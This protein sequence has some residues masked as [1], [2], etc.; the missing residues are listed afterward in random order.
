M[1]QKNVS[2]KFNFIMNALLT[3]SSFVFPLITFPYVS[4]IL[5]PTGLGRVSFAQSLV[6]YFLIFSEL[7]ISSYGIRITAQLR[8]DKL[9]LS[10]NTQELFAINLFMSLVAYASLVLAICMLPKL[11]DNAE[12]ILICSISILF[13]ALGMEWLYKG[14]EQY[15]YITCRSLLFKTISLVLIFVFIHTSAD[16]KAYAL[17]TVF[18]TSASGILNFI[19]VRRYI[20][21]KPCFGYEFRHHFKAILTFF[22]MSCATTI[23]TNL[24]TVMLGFM[25]N[26]TEVGYYNAAIRFKVILVAAVTSLGTVL[27]PRASYYAEQGKT[28]ELKRIIGIAFN[29]VVVAALPLMVF[30]II[31]ARES[32]LFIAGADYMPSVVPMQIIMPIVLLIALSNVT[33]IQILVPL[34]GERFV[35]YSEIVGAVI[36]IIINALLIPGYGAS[37]AAIGTLIAEIAVLAV[38]SYYLT[39]IHKEYLSTLRNIRYDKIV[40]A[41][42]VASAAGILAKSL[43]LH[44]FIVL[45]ISA[46]IY[47]GVYGM[48]LLIMREKFV[49]DTFAQLTAKLKAGRKRA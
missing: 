43:E 12:L 41:V 44:V 1:Q 46:C 26:N 17:L 34:G 39:H 7:G 14:L 45:I 25:S 11:R 31:F 33:G 4:R 48:L 3:M 42:I 35:L 27:L 37:G 6:S 36:D 23:Y 47:F 29:F 9:K 49:T 22:A 38:Q 8:D 13:N 5:E 40:V 10:R 19:N 2:I 21:L 28:D 30:F 15:T 18:A 32:I 16:Y 20:S 24:D